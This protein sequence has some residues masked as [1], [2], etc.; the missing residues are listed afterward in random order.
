MTQLAR[1]GLAVLAQA[2]EFLFGKRSRGGV[3]IFR[4][5]CMGIV[6]GIYAVC[7]VSYGIEQRSSCPSGMYTCIC[8]GKL[9]KPAGVLSRPLWE[10]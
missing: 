2:A 3:Y 4:S 7:V 8:S 1:R 5:H 10:L 9:T 6:L